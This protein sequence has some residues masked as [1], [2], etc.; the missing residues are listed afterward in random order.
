MS[1]VYFHSLSGD[2][3]LRGAERAWGDNLVTSIASGVL[4]EFA[5]F[6]D[7]SERIRQLIKPDHYLRREMGEPLY[8]PWWQSF[9]IAASGR[10]SG[11]MLEWNGKE[12][13]TFSLAL[14]TALLL[15]ND[16]VKLMA[17]LHGQC[18]LHGY[19]EGEDREWYAGLIEE[20]RKTSLLR[21]DMGWEG[22]ISLL[23]ERDDEPVVT[24]YSVTDSF[25]NP[26][27]AGWDLSDDNEYDEKSEMFYNLSH[28][29]MWEISLNGL[30]AGTQSPRWSP[31]VFTNQKF[32]HELSF[33][34]LLEPDVLERIESALSRDTDSLPT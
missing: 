28:E 31:E 26:Y 22:V 15:G 20:G 17:F 2:A 29:E 8:G 18:E 6:G 33:F 34:D 11:S 16:T 10:L 7:Q 21:P 3:I 23:R 12:I 32:G 19:L 4:G 5:P 14:N 1:R 27:I 9:R 13:S 24:S 30:R 25:P